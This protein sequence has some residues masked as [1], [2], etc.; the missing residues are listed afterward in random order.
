MLRRRI[1]RLGIPRQAIAVFIQNA[2]PILEPLTYQS[3]YLVVF[4]LFPRI[5][6]SDA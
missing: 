1:V 4:V 5:F 3:M 6:E 2:D